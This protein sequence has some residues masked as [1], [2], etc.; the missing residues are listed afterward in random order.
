MTRVRIREI[1]NSEQ[2]IRL[3]LQRIRQAKKIK[4]IVPLRF[5]QWFSNHIWSKYFWN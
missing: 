4:R 5:R 3:I 2:V 1:V